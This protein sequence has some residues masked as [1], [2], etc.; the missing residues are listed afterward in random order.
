MTP[1]QACVRLRAV[2]DSGYGAPPDPA[3]AVWLADA[4]RRWAKEKAPPE[5]LV[6]LLGLPTHGGIELEARNYWLRMASRALPVRSAK[7]CATLLSERLQRIAR[8]GW[9]GRVDRCDQALAL[10]FPSGRVEAL[11]PRQLETI[12]RAID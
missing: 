5:M 7:Q 9:P 12:I 6:R 2:L 11:K 1:A 3:S 8:Q 10:A 4:L